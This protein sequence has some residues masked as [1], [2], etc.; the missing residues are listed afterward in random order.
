MGEQE[1]QT[2]IIYQK[3]NSKV[4]EFGSLKSLKS[5]PSLLKSKMLVLVSEALNLWQFYLTFCNCRLIL[6]TLNILFSV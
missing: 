6:T 5:Y 1:Q 3:I 4:I 2:G